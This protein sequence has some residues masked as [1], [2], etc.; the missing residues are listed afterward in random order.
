MMVK[1]YETERRGTRYEEGVCVRESERDCVSECV[2]ECVC[3]CERE[4]VRERVGEKVWGLGHEAMT[5]ANRQ[6]GSYLLIPLLSLSI[7]AAS[8]TGRSR[9]AGSVMK[10]FLVADTLATAACAAASAVAG[11]GWRRAAEYGLRVPPW[12]VMTVGNLAYEPSFV[13]TWLAFGVAWLVNVGLQLAVVPG[14][15]RR[16][17]PGQV[18]TFTIAGVLFCASGSVLVLLR[19]RAMRRARLLLEVDALRYEAVWA[20]TLREEGLDVAALSVEVGAFLAVI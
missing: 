17:A 18:N 1:E 9:S 3:V 15:D 20:D 4:R 11:L 7:F 10:A 14:G 8:V 12:L 2:R 6:V 19:W 13:T 16:Q 5:L